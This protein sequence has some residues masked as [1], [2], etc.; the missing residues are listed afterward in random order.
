[1]FGYVTPCRMELKVKDF[2]KFK[3]YYCGLCHSIKKD[4]GNIPR[5]SLNYDMTFLAILLDSLNSNRLNSKKFTCALHPLEKKLLIFDNAPLKYAAECNIVLT[6]YKL[7]DNINDDN[8]LKSRIASIILKK[9]IKDNNLNN[10]ISNSLNTLYNMEKEA[11]KYS[12]DEIS[13]AFADL[14]GSIIS[15]YVDDTEE[16]KEQLYWLGY[17]LGKWIYIIDAWDDLE[18]DMK[19]NKFNV[20]AKLYNNDGYDYDSLKNAV[21]E[22]IDFILTSCAATCLELLQN[23]PLKKNKELLLNILE[24]GLMEKMDTVFKRSEIVNGESI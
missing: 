21:E 12:M 2:E 3:A 5:I 7:I 4:Y 19:N 1:M 8:S 13:H 24:L 14:T 11:Y 10:I 22:R 18:K 15:N 17:N 9:Y 16:Y 23:L 6:Y 20:I